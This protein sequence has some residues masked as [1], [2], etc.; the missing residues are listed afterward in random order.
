MSE[1]KKHILLV[2]IAEQSNILSILAC[3]MDPARQQ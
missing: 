1:Q 3:G 2:C